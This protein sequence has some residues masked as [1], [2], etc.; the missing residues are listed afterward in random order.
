MGSDIS[1]N[2]VS[3]IH[4][5]GALASQL[6]PYVRSMKAANGTGTSPRGPILGSHS[7]KI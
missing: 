1:T 5:H 2:S 4:T 7:A 6:Y 3:F